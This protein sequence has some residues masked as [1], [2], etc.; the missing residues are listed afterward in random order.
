MKEFAGT[1][2]KLAKWLYGV[3]VSTLPLHGRD[4][5]S[6]PFRVTILHSLSVRIWPFQGREPGSIPGVGNRV[7]RTP[8]TDIMPG[9]LNWIERKTSNL[10]VLGSSPRSGVQVFHHFSQKRPL[11]QVWP[12]GLRRRT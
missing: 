12:S 4:K 7:V 9:W 1:H 8:K 2:Q 11:K 6:I 10:E 5:G 3:A